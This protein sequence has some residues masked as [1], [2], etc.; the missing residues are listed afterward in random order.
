MHVGEV[1]KFEDHHVSR[2]TETA[3]SWVRAGSPSKLPPA[4]GWLGKM[5][6]CSIQSQLGGWV[7][8]RK[9]RRKKTHQPE[10]L[11]VVCLARRE[12]MPLSFNN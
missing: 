1:D 6:N 8:G 7:C 2:A 5:T 12:D 10:A 9:G 11:S 4:L 3:E